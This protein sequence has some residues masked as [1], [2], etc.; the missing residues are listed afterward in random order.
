MVWVVWYQEAY[1]GVC[2]DGKHWQDG[3]RIDRSRPREYVN[4]L[5]L[6][7]EQVQQVVESALTQSAQVK[8]SVSEHRTRGCAAPHSP[9]GNAEK[10]LGNDEALG[11]WVGFHVGASDIHTTRHKG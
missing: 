10:V 11:C 2:I 5:V 1:G 6:C 3:E 7:N 9:K 8:Q 4:H